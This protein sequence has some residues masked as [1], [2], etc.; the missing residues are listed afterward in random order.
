MSWPDMPQ[1]KVLGLVLILNVWTTGGIE[2]PGNFGP[3]GGRV[4][5]KILDHRDESLR[6]IW[7]TG[8]ASHLE[9]FGKDD[10]RNKFLLSV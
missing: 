4:T 1:K 3:P 5:W 8:R 6:K 10:G 7:T 9:K 2:S